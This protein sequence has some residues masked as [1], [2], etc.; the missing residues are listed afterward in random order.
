M[1]T[2]L[3]PL[4]PYDDLFVDVFGGGGSVLLNRRRSPVEVYNDLD[5]NLVNLFRVLQTD[6]LELERR[7]RSTLYSKEEFVKAIHIIDG[8]SEPADD[9]ERAWAMFVN[10][11]QS[12]VGRVRR[13][14][15]NWSRAAISVSGESA[16][17]AGWKSLVTR[18]GGVYDRLSGVQVEQRDA[19]E[20]VQY[21][22]GPN[23]VL[24]VDPPYVHDTRVEDEYY[25]HEMSNEQHEELVSTLLTAQ[26]HVVVSGY[27]YPIY[28]R[29]EDNGWARVEFERVTTMTASQRGKDE[30]WD[31][32]VKPR[33]K[34]TEVVW[35]NEKANSLQIAPS[36]LTIL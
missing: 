28:N 12:V 13:T 34:R 18:L 10:M 17:V 24:Y 25:A 20:C 8:T 9:V 29:L 15:G 19:I 32:A 23:T 27:D 31:R 5:S 33:G 22:D 11:N 30:D 7:L 35:L 26:G 1:L 14:Q 3:L 36:L 16:V 4:I 21:W 2:E 6:P